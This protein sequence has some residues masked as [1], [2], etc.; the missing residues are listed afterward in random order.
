MAVIKRK[1]LI[2]GQMTIDE[3]QDIKWLLKDCNSKGDYTST[4]R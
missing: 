3:K 4:K 1:L 2:F